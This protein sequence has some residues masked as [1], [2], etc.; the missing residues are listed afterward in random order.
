MAFME[1]KELGLETGYEFP[2]PSFLGME[3]RLM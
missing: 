2:W 3:E 1:L